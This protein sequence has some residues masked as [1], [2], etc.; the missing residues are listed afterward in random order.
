MRAYYRFQRF[1]LVKVN[2]GTGGV[3]PTER[4]VGWWERMQ[5][6]MQAQM[7]EKQRLTEQQAQRIEAKNDDDPPSKPGPTNGKPTSNPKPPSEVFVPRSAI[8][9][10]VE[11]FRVAWTQ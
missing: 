3:F 10:A 9:E 5:E 1:P 7:E 11:A 6:Q 4:K 2:T 8:P